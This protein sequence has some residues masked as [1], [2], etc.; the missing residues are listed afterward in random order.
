MELELLKIKRQGDKGKSIMQEEEAPV[1][2]TP[3]EKENEDDIE[4]WLVRVNFHLEK[5]M[6]RANMDNQIIGHM[7]YH[8]RT[9]KKTF[10]IRVKQMKARLRRA[11]K[12]KKTR[13]GL[14]CLLK[15]PW[16]I[17]LLDEGAAHQF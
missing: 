17:I 8:Y 9:L 11:L 5:L 2:L 7:A 15:L 13:I 3:I 4:I 14:C 6:Q 12:G 1:N 16:L 10:N